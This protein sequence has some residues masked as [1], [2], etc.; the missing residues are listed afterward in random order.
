[1]FADEAVNTAKDDAVRKRKKEAAKKTKKK[2]APTDD[3]V[4]EPATVL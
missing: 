2:K 1:M 3:F 4:W